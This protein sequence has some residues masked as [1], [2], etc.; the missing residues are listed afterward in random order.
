MPP[1]PLARLNAAP[2]D[3]A[4]DAVLAQRLPAAGKV[5]AFVGMEHL[6][7]LPRAATRSAN[8]RDGIDDI[9]E[10]LRVADVGG[11][12]DHC[13]RDAVSIDYKVALRALFAAIRRV[14][15]ALLP[16]GSGYT[17]RVQGRPCPVD[18]V[19]FSQPEVLRLSLVQSQNEQRLRSS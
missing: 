18:A 12:V 19:R 16:S 2:G 6:G 5:V 15:A 7:P 17:R 4:L 13:E 14:W 8:R 11:S 9:L 10:G 1:Q 3:A